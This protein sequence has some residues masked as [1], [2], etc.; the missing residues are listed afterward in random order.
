MAGMAPV[1]VGIG[2]ALFDGV[3]AWGPALA[4]FV[5]AVFIQIG[6]NFANDVADFKH[7]ADTTERVGP[8]RVTQAGLLTPRQVRAG[9]WICFSLAGIA[10]IFLI[11]VAGWPVIVIGLISIAAGIAYT[12]GPIPLGYYGLGDLMVFIFFGPTAVIG[13]YYVQALT[14][15]SLVAW[16]SISI[17]ALAT[18]ILVVNNLRDIETD[19]AASKNTLA[20][21]LGRLGTQIEYLFLITLA[22]AIPVGLVITGYAPTTVLLS[23]FSLPLGISLIRKVFRDQ[24]PLLNPVLGRTSQLELLFALLLTIGFNI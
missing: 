18:S 3:F 7:G 24:G 11:S 17:G 23:L 14:A 20:V 15:T 2:V 16:V 4:A 19:K 12:G 9:M 1:V 6:A 21:R 10:G 8:L 5:G 13:T 22:Y